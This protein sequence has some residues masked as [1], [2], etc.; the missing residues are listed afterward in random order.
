MQKNT[1]FAMALAFVL[2]S[3]ASGGIEKARHINAAEDAEVAG[4]YD[5]AIASWTEAIRV[6]P[7]D[8]YLYNFYMRR[9][10]ALAAKR[11]YARALADYNEAIRLNSRSPAA[12]GNRGN[13]YRAMREYD[14]SLEDFNRAI[15]LRDRSQTA[16]LLH[17]RAAT[18]QAKGDLDRAIADYD[19]LL[20][21]HSYNAMTL[22]NRGMILRQKGEHDRALADFNEA[23]R[24]D[25][26]KGMYYMNRGMLRLERGDAD[27]A[28]SD[29]LKAADT[30]AEGAPRLLNNVAWRLATSPDDR[31][32]NG[33]RAVELATRACELTGWTNT[34]MDTLAAAHAENGDFSEAV[35]WQEKAAQSPATSK[36][37]AEGMEQRLLL[38]RSGKPFRTK[39]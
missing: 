29:A 8:A 6:S 13:L 38:Y 5:R 12:Y 28:A 14:R 25:P 30:K 1:L 11:E 34:Y 36:S 7:D 18:Y 23:V 33:Q 10:N 24:L 27:G 3:C 35:K 37:A 20:K 39:G 21:Y 16:S 19:E 32:R 4:D 15:W 31:T 2:A 9:G 22:N 26:S 17:N